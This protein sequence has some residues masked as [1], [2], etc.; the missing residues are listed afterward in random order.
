VIFYNFGEEGKVYDE[1]LAGLFNDY[2]S[3]VI[4]KVELMSEDMACVFAQD[5]ICFYSIKNRVN[6][7]LA[8]RYDFTEEISS[9]FCRNGYAGV[10]TDG[11]GDG[12]KK[13][14]V[15]DSSGKFLWEKKIDFNYSKASFADDCV[16][17]YN[18]EHCLIYNMKGKLKYNGQLNGTILHMSVK[19]QKNIIMAG[20]HSLKGIVLK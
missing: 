7:K 9:V 3:S 17:I 20:I 13:L 4:G 11:G 15:Y 5:R 19:E 14:S 8:K 18:D 16:V 6:I 10:I 12:F 1:R 2:G